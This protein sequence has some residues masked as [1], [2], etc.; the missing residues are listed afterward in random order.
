MELSLNKTAP[1]GITETSPLSLSVIH[2]AA[3]AVLQSSTEAVHWPQLETKVYRS[4]PTRIPWLEPAFYDEVSLVS[5][6]DSIQR[7]DVAALVISAGAMS[8]R[9]IRV[10]IADHREILRDALAN[11][12]G[13][14][15]SAP[16]LTDCD[17]YVLPF[18]A[19]HTEVALVRLPE[20]QVLQG[21]L[22]GFGF[23]A[24][25]IDGSTDT[26]LRHRVACT[27]AQTPGWRPCLQYRAHGSGDAEAIGWQSRWGGGLVILSLLPLERLPEPPVFDALLKRLTW[28]RGTLAVGPVASAP[29]DFL[30][31]RPGTYLAHIEALFPDVD[32][33]TRDFGHLRISD[34][35]A[36]MGT[37]EF[38]KSSILARNEKNGTFEV[39]TSM[40]D[41]QM[42]RI[43]F[44]GVPEYMSELEWAEPELLALAPLLPAGPTFDLLAYALCAH[45]AR[46]VVTNAEALPE[47]LAVDASA[48]LCQEAIEARLESGSVD[49]R[50]LPTV[51]VLAACH[52]AGIDS[53]QTTDGWRWVEDE[54]RDSRD[55]VE[56]GQIGWV[57]Q[58]VGHRLTDL[59]FARLREFG[60]EEVDRESIVGRLAVNI[61]ENRWREISQQGAPVRHLETALAAFTWN[62]GL[63]RGMW[64]GYSAPALPLRFRP[65]DGVEAMLYGLAARIM[66]LRRAPLMAGSPPSHGGAHA[67]TP[68][69]P[70]EDGT[71]MQALQ[72]QMQMAVDRSESRALKSERDELARVANHVLGVLL[73]MWAAAVAVC[74]VG[75]VILLFPDAALGDWLAAIGTGIAVSVGGIIAANSIPSVSRV[76]PRWAR[77][78]L[79]LAGK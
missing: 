56:L 2:R 34:P 28:S 64:P 26:I 78:S 68:H 6:M 42:C 27:A 5:L 77:W 32:T 60:L 74:T 30:E 76:L 10:A 73:G 48:T 1:A 61:H 47:I 46:A 8:N 36:M 12:M 14:A 63:Q 70:Q 31:P 19:G 51:N 40:V 37:H 39:M 67:A 3:V 44:S 35:S 66:H 4:I 18:L 62:W 17:S 16:F 57:L 25:P 15:L 69:R 75:V 9:Q 50:L 33:R 29:Q 58:V 45:A 52:V 65:Q 72:R 49:G 79:R 59:T 71:A 22:Q 11:G 55:P 54:L 13:L 20:T 43:H 41:E 53:R 7:G 23:D 38:T 24:I 21:H